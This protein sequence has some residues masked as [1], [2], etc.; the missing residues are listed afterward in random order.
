VK[1]S[2]KYGKNHRDIIQTEV[3]GSDPI[4]LP[5][6]Y[7]EFKDYYG[8]CEMQTKRWFLENVK[9]DWVC[10]DAGANIGYHSILLGRLGHQVYAFEPTETYEMLTGNLDYAGAKNVI[11]VRLGLGERSWEGFEKIYKIWGNEPEEML[12]EFT[13]IDDFVA[14]SNITNVDL[15]KID[16]DGFDFEVVRGAIKTLGEFSPAVIIEINHALATRGY[17]SSEVFSFMLE[18]KYDTALVLDDENYVFQKTWKLGQPWPAGLT[19]SFDQRK[20]IKDADLRVSQNAK[21]VS[22]VDYLKLAT[23]ENNAVQETNGSIFLEGPAWS[24]AQR[25]SLPTIEKHDQ[26]FVVD[27]KVTEGDLGLFLSD[28]GG[29][30]LLT[31]ETKVHASGEARV[32]LQGAFGQNTYLIARKMTAANLRFKINSVSIRQ[33]E[34][35]KTYPNPISSLNSSEFAVFLGEQRGAS[36]RDHP[37]DNINIASFSDL[38]L[39]LGSTDT[40]DL[41]LPLVNPGSLLMETNDAIVIEW[42]YKN[43]K[44][45]RHL[46]FGT[47]EGF[48][49]T[50][51]LRAGDGDVWT[52]DL[53]EGDTDDGTAIHA[54][55]REPFH[56]WVKSRIHGGGSNSGSFVGWMYRQAGLSYRVHQIPADSKSLKSSDFPAQG[57]DTTLIDGARDRE[58]VGSDSR[59]ALKLISESGVLMW[60][61]FSLAQAVVTA[62]PSCEG[63]LAAIADN[64]ELL[65]AS[66]DLFWVEGTMLLIGVPR[67]GKF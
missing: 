57:F 38:R 22:S 24:Y 7:P 19:I 53:P 62:Q 43:R 28:Y 11:P 41:E 58:T 37:L 39:R 33:V 4:F 31:S 60:H 15:I 42:V 16:V 6:H 23:L 50:L 36:W 56:P 64:I 13:T 49:T 35:V 25:L 45:N 12:V 21:T 65:T 2:G 30:T 47:G 18:Q 9:K 1:I 48:G 3:P 27:V 34:Q 32:I 44:P 10:L 40:M 20:P 17:S 14:K 52:I 26:A 55:S 63:V 8:M 46:E 67:R 54:D 5:R 51:C 61:N 29:S 59:L 66:R